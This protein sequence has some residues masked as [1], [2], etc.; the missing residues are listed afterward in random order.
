MAGYVYLAFGLR[1]RSNLP[2]PGLLPLS[3]EYISDVHLFLSALPPWLE[4]QQDSSHTVWHT[5]A[6]RNDRGEPLLRIWKV[7]HGAYFR[8]LHDDGIEFVMD[9]CGREIWA[10]WPEPMTLEDALTY[11]LGPVLAF[12]LRL[13]GMTTLHASAACIDA[14]AVA[15]LGPQGAGKSTTAAALARSGCSVLCDDIVALREYDE[16]MVQPAHPRLYL[17]PDSVKALYN[18]KDRLPPLTP[19][20]EK[21]YLDLT[22]NGYRF[23]REALP[24]GVVYFLDQRSES[25]NAPFIESMSAT[26]AFM[27]LVANSY[28]GSRLDKQM[29]A[30]EFDLLGRIVSRVALR[31]LVPHSDSARLSKLCEIVLEDSRHLFPA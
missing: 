6:Y 14:T 3:A 10:A 20:W 4:S 8:F 18:S 21:R 11:L 1:L 2:I 30:R 15:F 19:N 7:Q 27:G 13:R 12:V 28:G 25:P 16:L 5:S 26:D 22:N 29:R 23:Q 31:R 17:W 9:S 24:L